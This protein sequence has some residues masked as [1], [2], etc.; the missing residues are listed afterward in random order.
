MAKSNSRRIEVST[1]A[2]T[3]LRL[4]QEW[5][6]SY[7]ADTELLLVANSQEAAN[8]LHLRVVESRGAAF[9]IKRITLN[10]LA[11][12]L[13]Q[14]LL[15]EHGAA[16]ATNLTFT[17]VVARVI[18]SLHSKNRLTYFG[19]VANKPGFSIAVAKTLVE[20]RMNKVESRSL[21]QLM[22][23]GKDSHIHGDRFT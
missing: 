23:G 1:D 7:S 14:R 17:A 9:G 4:A 19:P 16:P 2:A 13:A 22:R 18:H 3:R 11:S 12:R 8:D 20:L 5:I 6:E 21:S 10:F 15:V